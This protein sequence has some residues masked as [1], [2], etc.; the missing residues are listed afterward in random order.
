MKTL[1]EIV[2]YHKTSNDLLE[3]L[4]LNG[5]YSES[6][7]LNSIKAKYEK[8]GIPVDIILRKA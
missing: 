3:L 2:V 5:E 8:L 6:V 1:S 4:T 7:R